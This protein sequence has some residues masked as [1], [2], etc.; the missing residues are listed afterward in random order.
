MNERMRA[1][2]M[3]ITGSTEGELGTRAWRG[4]GV[5][6]LKR[7]SRALL[8]LA[9]A[10]APTT[11]SSPLA[12]ATPTGSAAASPTLDTN[13]R[14]LAAIQRLDSRVGFV[15]GWTGTRVGLAKT[16]DA[17]ATWQRIGVPA[18]LITTLR[19]I[20]E[21]VGW[22][23][24]F[25]Q[26]DVPQVACQ[27]A[28]PAGARLCWGVLLRT[29]DGGRTW[30]ETLSLPTDGVRGYPI[31]QFQAVDGQHAWVLTLLEPCTEPCPMELRR[32]TDG[33]KTWNALNLSA[34]R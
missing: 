5:G 31:R 21:R 9:T 32:T 8:A 6:G 27:Q 19:F 12:S 25:V 18:S 7:L 30:Q 23:G 26:R 28:A 34:L 17:G 20:D 16:T 3:A 14:S 1:A 29:E 15:T 2:A 10:C 33:G 24:A 13:P 11:V 4:R 22:A